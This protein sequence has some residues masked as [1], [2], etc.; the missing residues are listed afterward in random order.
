M[1]SEILIDWLKGSGMKVNANKT[2]F[3]VFHRNDIQPK[4][5]I[6]DNEQIQSKTTIKVLGVLLDSKLNWF[7]HVTETIIKCKKTLQAI[8]L[9]SSFFTIDERL[10]IITSLFYSK[11]YY[12]A[13]VWLLPTLSYSLQKKILQISTYALRI[14]AN[15][16]YYTFNG[17]ELHIMFKRF[18]PTQWRTYCNLLSI[19][20][21][22]NHKI[23]VEIWLELQVNALP[24]TRANR[25]LFPP[26]NKL[27]IGVN[28][29][30]NR[31]SYASTLITN[32]NLNLSY[33]SFK[34]LA[35]NIVIHT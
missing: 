30:C 7:P 12:G 28:S 26:K 13:E 8:K 29:I 14:A 35:K 11:L 6:L 10:N 20:R 22:F 1:K 19:Y 21:I 2:E 24:L 5:I 3:C 31:L 16:Q 25:T 32:E 33:D 27:K 17:N 34:V 18:T 23:P 15:D 9:I 4:M